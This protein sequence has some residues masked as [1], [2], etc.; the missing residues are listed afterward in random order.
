MVTV[1]SSPIAVWA[2]CAFAAVGA[3]RRAAIEARAADNR[4]AITSCSASIWSIICCVTPTCTSAG[5]A[6]S[7][8][9]SW[10]LVSWK[11]KLSHAR[12]S[13]WARAASPSGNRLS[14][15]RNR[16]RS[17]RN[18]AWITLFMLIVA[19]RRR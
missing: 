19:T 10:C 8:S 13:A 5:H 2:V 9:P 4:S 3:A 16:S 12:P 1:L 7:C 6:I 11:S 14:A 15:P 17:R 18:A